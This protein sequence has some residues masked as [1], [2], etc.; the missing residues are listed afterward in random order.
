MGTDKVVAL[1]LWLAMAGFEGTAHAEAWATPSGLNGGG[2]GMSPA[3]SGRAWL[4][5]S[6]FTRAGEDRTIAPGI[7][8]SR[9]G[10]TLLSPILGFGIQVTPNVELE[11]VLPVGIYLSDNG[12][13]GVGNPFVG[14]S[15]VLDGPEVR[16]KAGG[17]FAFPVLDAESDDQVSGAVAGLF[18]R[19][20][21]T[22]WLW[23]P[24]ALAVVFPVHVEA[25][26]N[27]PVLFIGD[28]TPYMLIPVRRRSSTDM[29]VELAPG[30]GG[31][32]S[33]DVVIG[34]RMP[35]VL[36]VTG[37]SAVGNQDKAQVS[38]EP[39]LRI[40]SDPVFFSARFTMPID[41]PLGFAFDEGKVWGL[42][43]G[44]GGAF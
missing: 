38:L 23:A 17:G 12:A 6:L 34:V 16:F 13:A 7:Q 37:N 41:E 10:Y 1:G 36:A 9:A 24:D 35:L 4:D 3:Q 20:I 22:G 26:L 14:V 30:L 39:F 2:L 40:A 27:S 25:P 32:V 5:V 43:V 18:T 31:Y 28:A 42:N 19:A 33:K 21:Q 44:I 29:L 15:Y 8:V 11:A